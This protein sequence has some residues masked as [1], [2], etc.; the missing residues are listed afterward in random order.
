MGT[1]PKNYADFERTQHAP[2]LFRINHAVKTIIHNAPTLREKILHEY[3]MIQEV[4]EVFGDDDTKQRQQFT[5]AVKRILDN[6]G[7]FSDAELCGISARL[8]NWLKR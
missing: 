4:A 7:R 5:G 1:T 6:T 8:Y 2:D 3:D